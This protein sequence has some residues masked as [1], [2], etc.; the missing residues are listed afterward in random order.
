MLINM[1]QLKYAN[2]WEVFIYLGHLT[3][4]QIVLEKE[5]VVG[6]S[7]NRLKRSPYNFEWKHDTF[8]H[9]S[10]NTIQR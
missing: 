1:F 9:I 2:L 6:C 10:D 4:D 7:T 8:A 3:P 5:I